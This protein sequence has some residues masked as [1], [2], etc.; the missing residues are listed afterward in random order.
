MSGTYNADE[1]SLTLVGEFFTPGGTVVVDYNVGSSFYQQIVTTD[2]DGTFRVTEGGIFC[3]PIPGSQFGV[4]VTA[5]DVSSG[6]STTK[7][8]ETPC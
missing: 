1:Q 4:I 5:Y 3:G 7:G 2:S 8:F 6:K